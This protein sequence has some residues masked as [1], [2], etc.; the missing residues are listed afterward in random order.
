MKVYKTIK[1]FIGGKFPR[2]ESGR[3][4]AQNFHKTDKHYAHLCQASRKDLRAAVE[5]ARKAQP[6]W[7]ARAAFNRAQ[8]LYRMAEMLE[9][10]RPEFEQVFKDT[11]GWA[12]AKSEKAIDEAI[13]A[14]VYYGG[15]SDKYQQTTSTVNPVSSPHHNFT[16]PEA[17]GVTT[18]IS[19]DKFDFGKLAADIAGIICSGNSVVVILGPECPAVLA[20]L[21]EVFATSDLPG[22]VINLLT[23]DIDEL[24]KHTAT[25]MEINSISYQ[26]ENE[27]RYFEM[28]ELAIDNMKRLIPYSK[29]PLCVEKILNFV[30]YKTVWHPVGY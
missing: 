15:F 3:S 29:D 11:L 9:G 14:F 2:T 20:P 5:A 13:D 18:L 25:H 4:F 26:N 7:Q 1:L 10:K 21:A 19:A 17:V 8:I 24:Y 12:K 27:K 16:M 23:G 22:G 6:G 28:K 30:E